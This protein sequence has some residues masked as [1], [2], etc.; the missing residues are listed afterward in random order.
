VTVVAPL[1]GDG[2]TVAFTL[3]TT[4]TNAQYTLVTISGVVQKKTTYS[5]SG[6]VLTFVTAPTNTS[7]VEVTTFGP[8]ITTATAAGA[9]T[10][11]Q[12]N[13]SGGLAASANLTFNTGSNTLNA[14]NITATTI[15]ANGSPVVSTG[16]SIAMSIVFGG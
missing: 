1:T 14:T 16:K 9:N 10:Q 2:S 5:V 8:A 6:A 15:T 4:P 13:T 12:F 11:V 7:P 3:S